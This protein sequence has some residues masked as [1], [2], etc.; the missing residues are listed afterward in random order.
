MAA[1]K[2]LSKGLKKSKKLAAA[3]PLKKWLPAN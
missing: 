1:R 2:K 3:R